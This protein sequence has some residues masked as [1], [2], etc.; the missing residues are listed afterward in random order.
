MGA[1]PHTIVQKGAWKV[2]NP[3][4]AVK[5]TL[6]EI[7]YSNLTYIN[8]TLDRLIERSDISFLTNSIQPH[9]EWL[10]RQAKCAHFYYV[11]YHEIATLDND[12]YTYTVYLFKTESLFRKFSR[13]RE[14]EKKNQ[15]SRIY[16]R[17]KKY[18]IF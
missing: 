14:D 1:W 11:Y 2:E 12:K 9:Q 16:I 18:M 7:D 4:T 3:W 6:Y 17:F 10:I 15:V 8:N 13:K 5:H